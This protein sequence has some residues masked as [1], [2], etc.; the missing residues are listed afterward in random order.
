MLRHNLQKDHC[1][2]GKGRCGKLRTNS[3]NLLSGGNCYN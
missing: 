2:C 1:D 3:D